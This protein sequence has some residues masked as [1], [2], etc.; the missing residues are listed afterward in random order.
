MDPRFI[1]GYEST[2]KLGFIVV[3]FCQTHNWNIPTD[4]VTLWITQSIF[5]RCLPCLLARSLLADGHPVLFCVFTSQFLP[6]SPHLVVDHW[7]C[8]QLCHP[9]FYY[10][11]LKSR[12]PQSRIQ[13]R[14][15]IDWTEVFQMKVLYHTTRSSV[16][17]ISGC[18]T[19]TEQHSVVKLQT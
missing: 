17:Y 11:K 15:D 16:Y 12:L 9:T 19:N 14:F 10:G 8:W 3:K 6:W 4:F 18:Q 7:Q 13:L 5:L 1:H 2:Q